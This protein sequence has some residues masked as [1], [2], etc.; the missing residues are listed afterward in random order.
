MTLKQYYRYIKF[1]IFMFFFWLYLTI[2]KLF[3]KLLNR[4]F[5]QLPFKRVFGGLEEKS[6]LAVLFW[7]LFFF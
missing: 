2:K 6:L 4:V 1:K 3:H 5:V 7:S